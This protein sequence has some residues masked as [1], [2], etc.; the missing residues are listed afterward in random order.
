MMK[1]LVFLAFTGV[2]MATLTATAAFAHQASPTAGATL[3]FEVVT[4]G[5]VPEDTT[6]FGL[7]GPPNSEFSALQL[8]DP[9][10]DGAYTGAV[11]L[12]RGEYVVRIDQGTGTQETVYG[13][14]PGEP[15]ST[16]R[17]Q[18]TITLDED[19]TISTHAVFGSEPDEEQATLSFDVVTEGEVPQDT[20]FRAVGGPPDGA[21]SAIGLT[22]PDE[23]G[24]YTGSVDLDTGEYRVFIEQGTSGEPGRSTIWG[25]EII[26]LTGDRTISTSVDF[27]SEPE[28]PGEPQPQCFLPEG[29]SISGDDS[30]EKI[31]GGIG[32]DY[33]VGGAGDD[34]LHGLGGGDWLDGGAG[35]DLVRGGDG[36][37]LVDGGSG[38]DLVRGNDGNDYV[39]G[40]TGNDILEAGGGSDFIYAADGEFDEVSGGPGYDVCV[41]DE[42]DDVRGCEEVYTQ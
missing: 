22:D 5:E 35:D 21:L 3:A 31:V 18:E 36:D 24:T 4:E 33:I 27:G 40:F 7:Y 16:I 11:E 2:L 38:D 20:I 8:T 1:R 15:S 26:T 6:F 13:T 30:D 29:C 23:D 12:E 34:A 39:S 37:D 17:G 32:P 42:D 14:F 41:V 19:T 10:G 25:P 9:D 28:E